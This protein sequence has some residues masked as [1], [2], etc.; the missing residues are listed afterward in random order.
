MSVLEKKQNNRANLATQGRGEQ[1]FQSVGRIVRQ[2]F[3]ILSVPVAM[4][5]FV[6]VWALIGRL[7]D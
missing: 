6:G 4:I 2:R 3:E 7:G 5:V 1:W